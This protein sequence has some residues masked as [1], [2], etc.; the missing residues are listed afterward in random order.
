M[1]YYS[2]ITL[3]TIGYGDVTPHSIWGRLMATL[4]IPFAIVALT[5][6]MGNVHQLHTSK[7]MGMHKTLSQRLEELKEVI[8][9]D[10]NQRVTPEEFIL[11]NLK[12]MNKAPL[13]ASP[14]PL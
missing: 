5:T 11:F 12:K 6:F 7:K 10:D 8:E 3:A 1:F 14:L 9:Q 13:Y 4:L 2:I